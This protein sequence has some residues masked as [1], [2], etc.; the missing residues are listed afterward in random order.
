MSTNKDGSHRTQ[1]LSDEEGEASDGE[2]DSPEKVTSTPFHSDKDFTS[3]EAKR[4]LSIPPPKPASKRTEQKPKKSEE[5]KDKEDGEEATD[6]SDDSDSGSEMELPGKEEVVKIGPSDHPALVKACLQKRI[7]V[8][9]DDQT[10]ARIVRG[11][12]MGLE[13]GKELSRIQVE[14]DKTFKL[15]GPKD[16]PKSI[17][18]ISKHWV[19]RLADLHVLGE[20][21]LDE[22]K[23][24]E[25]WP[26]IYTWEN[27]VKHVNDIATGGLWSRRAKP[28]LVVIVPANS[29][30][31][32]SSYFLTL[33]HKE[34]SITRKSV[35]YRK[36][37][38]DGKKFRVQYSFCA[39]CGVLSM[40][41]KSGYSHLCK[42]L[43]VEFVCGG[44]LGYK[45]SD[46]LHISAHME[47]CTSCVEARGGTQ[48][49][50]TSTRKSRK[51]KAK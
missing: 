43:G 3:P 50:S 49:V 28:S 4:K 25:G 35:Y 9:I 5:E 36:V 16:G 26:Q 39:Y 48:W 37:E 8:Y 32:T 7:E 38:P 12:L 31:L 24:I 21:P 42:H 18:N 33:L 2:G 23:P 47:T 30:E 15:R 11:S 10:V 46:P 40:N 29:P 51:G 34:K 13:S 41:K 45:D 20:A 22:F 6:G 27:F 1:S 19:S 14:A 17:T 44:C